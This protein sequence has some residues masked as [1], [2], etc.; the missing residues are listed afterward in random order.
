MRK[1]L[2]YVI[3]FFTSVL[4]VYAAD[5]FE[6]STNKLTLGAVELS[7]NNYS[8][9]VATVNSYTVLGVDGGTTNGIGSFNPT[10]NLLTLSSV[11][12][13]GSTYVNARVIINNYT[14]QSVGVAC[15]APAMA[16]ASGTCINPPAA[17]GY[18]W[19]SVIKVWVADIGTLVTGL[20]TLPAEC[21]TIGDTCWK[22]SGKINYFATNM[23]INGRSLVM[24]GFL[25][26]GSDPVVSGNFNM[27]PIYSDT[28][29]DSPV[30]GKT[31]AN[32]S[33]S[34]GF[35]NAKGS[36]DGVKYTTPTNGCWEKFFTG[37]A[38][39]SRSISCPI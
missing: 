22:T 5:T 3:C 17:T 15:P 14:L 31:I 4:P 12:V 20:N 6:V 25:V 38:I 35:V 8:N 39:T 26:G 24:A 19:N 32:G 21:A 28:E 2:L 37:V 30:L 7:G 18:T 33:V 10:N 11:T 16:N 23:V 29:A 27:I 34:G 1:I 36:Q 13:Q 9:V